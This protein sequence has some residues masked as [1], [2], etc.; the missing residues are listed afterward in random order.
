MVRSVRRDANAERGHA[1]GRPIAG[2]G[3]RHR[4]L[5]P[6]VGV[7]GPVGGYAASPNPVAVAP[8]PRPDTHMQ[9]HLF[10]GF[11]VATIGASS[12]GL[13]QEKAPGGQEGAV[14]GE[15]KPAAPAPAPGGRVAP[16]APAT[17][18]NPWFAVTN[19]D[20]GTFFG[21]GD[22]VGVF[23]FK[24][25]G[26]QMI[27]WRNL[28]GSCQ[29]ARAVVRVGGRTY[30]LA[31]KPTPNQLTRVTKVQGQPDQIERVQQ[32]TIEPR[33]EG[34]VEVHL[35]MNQITGAKSASFDAHT[36][37][38]ALPQFKLNF[39][40]TGAQLFTT[41]P[42]EVNLN[43]MTWSE[44]RDFTVTVTS[45]TQKD[46]NIQRMDDAGKGFEV[47]YEKA[48]AG[49]K[50]SWVIKGKYGPVDGEM[51]G[52]GVLKFH[53]D[54]HGGATFSVRVIA[55]VQGPLEVKPGAFMSLG[56]I[57]KGNTMKKEV[58]FEPND[59]AQLEATALKFEKVTIPDAVTASSRRDGNKLIVEIMVSDT[60]PPG[61]LKGDLVVELNHPLVKEKRIMFNGFVR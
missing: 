30:E 15:V 24:N 39:H 31:A 49:D 14:Q 36:T 18:G 22:A 12:I 21:T 61:L 37:D 10:L 43:K 42:N 50:T 54:V 9:P 59:G 20:L 27:E 19:Q 1:C 17:G 52:G 46:W 57:R 44:S 2:I 60:S 3:R 26:D 8:R 35:D 23:K 29:C 16:R 13:A 58:V 11:L 53:T 33:A 4:A 48:A 5:A 28:T 40:A 47:A 55:M 45:P 56:L 38:P 7:F 32:I 41:S 25:P 34:E 6:P 51:A